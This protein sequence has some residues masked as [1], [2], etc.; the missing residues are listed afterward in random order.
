MRV[1]QLPSVTTGSFCPLVWSNWVSPH[2]VATLTLQ[3]LKCLL[4]RAL[5]VHLGGI[6][7]GSKSNASCWG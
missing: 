7:S 4:M 3:E 5:L 1:Q 2:T 6:I